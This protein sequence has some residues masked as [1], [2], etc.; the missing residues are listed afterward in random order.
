MLASRIDRLGS[1]QKLLLQT[2]SVI[3]K[4]FSGAILGAVAAAD[5]HS[6]LSATVLASSL[7]GLR[8]AEFIH[9]TALYPE[10]EYAFKHPLTQEVAYRS[11]LGE[12]DRNLLTY[13][14]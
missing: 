14:M 10:V 4:E 12:P 7:D 3:G 8:D 11:Q 5:D 1:D 6:S 13:S 9:E 2:A